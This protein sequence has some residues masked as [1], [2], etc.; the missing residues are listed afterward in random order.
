MQTKE[1]I[2]DIL[3][4]GAGPAGL[5]LAALLGGAGFSVILIDAEKPAPATAAPR[6]SGRT[7]AL[8]NSSLNVLKA[9][10]VWP[11]MIDGA[12]P[13]KTMRIVDDSVGNTGGD[14]PAVT[15]RAADA[16]LAQ[17]GFNVPN[18]ILRAALAARVKQIKSV[19]HLAPCR[20]SDYSVEGQHVIAR[21]EQGD[22]L[23]ASIIIGTD[24]R[25]SIV[26]AVS[27]IDVKTH[28]YT[29]IAM[30][31][32]IKHTK[33]HDYTSTE[34][35][36]PGGPFTLVPMPGNT[37]SVVWVE[38]AED[39]KRFLSMKQK[40]YEQA[41]Q[42]R[43]RGLLGTI[44]MASDPESWPLMMLNAKELIGDRSALAAEAAHVLSPIGAQGLNLSLRDVAALAET[45]TDAARLGEDIG[46]RIVL[47]RYQQRRRVD[48]QAHVIGI[49]G[50]NRAVANNLTAVKDLRRLGLRGLGAVPALRRL[51]MHQGLVPTMDEGR[52]VSG[53]AL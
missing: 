12:T 14:R 8:L 32:L 24:G 5:T 34:F 7:A 16:G 19:T 37:S 4:S 48:I 3:I 27:G 9:A 42:D 49:D 29:Q 6:A 41:I 31:C 21:T 10:E 2:A 43:S 52:I 15:F 46:S 23:R 13:L 53:G 47:N 26:R 50:L 40:E 25:G 30:T 39:S 28:D 11:D 18:A 45:I 51:V 22:V 38:K 35:H 33:P 17:F 44:T 1:R 36:R 20:L